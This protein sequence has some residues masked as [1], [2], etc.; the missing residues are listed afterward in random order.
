LWRVP[1]AFERP[2]RR[3]ATGRKAFLYFLKSRY[4]ETDVTVR[5]TAFRRAALLAAL[6]AL[7]RFWLAGRLN[8]AEDEAYYWEWSRSLAL[9]Y[10][11]QGPGLAF[12]IKAGTWLLGPTEQGVRLASVLSGFFVSVLAAWIVDTVF[13]L[14]DMALWVVLAFNGAL[15]F[16]VGGVMM[17][18]DSLM[19]LGWMGCMACGLQ[20]IRKGPR[21]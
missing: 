10:Y 19:A 17:M 2:L 15:I 11:D 20:A 5:F 13:G 1:G 9:S 14:A 3:P 12:A 7:L 6:F 16:A 18:H 8:L 21:C 4:N